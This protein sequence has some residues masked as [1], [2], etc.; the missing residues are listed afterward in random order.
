MRRKGKQDG[1][2]VEDGEEE[3]GTTTNGQPKM[4]TWKNNVVVE[5]RL[6]GHFTKYTMQF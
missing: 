4:R 2:N 6:D 1:E 5:G 3:V